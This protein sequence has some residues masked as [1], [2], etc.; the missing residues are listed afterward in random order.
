M[1]MKLIMMAA[2]VAVSGCVH[3][4]DPVGRGELPPGQPTVEDILTGLSENE[5]ALL[6]FRA[7]GT[8][9][10]KIP[11][12][13]ATQV[14]RESTLLFLSP[15]RLNVVGRR[16]GTRGIELTYVDDAFLIEFPTRREYCFKD[17]EESFETLSSAD[18]VR[19]MFTPE[20]WRDLSPR[21]VRITEYD[22]ES[23]TAELE[24]WTSERPYWPR[25][26]IRVQGAPWVL[27]ENVM[28]N[29]QGDVIARTV[30]SAYHEQAGIR[31]PTEIE[32]VFPGED[33]WM[34]FI[35][36][37]VDINLALDET[38]FNLSNRLTRLQS[39]GF[40]RVDIFAGEG[41]SIEDLLKQQQ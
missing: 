11:E 28:L 29:R 32:S 31:Y 21:D 22:E 13:D 10:V 36:R 38:V 7:S 9:M 30:K 15:N 26:I 20:A 41:P 35:M 12:I 25:R 39:S 17:M 19:E 6:S 40:K 14:S 5:A 24:I 33:A 8:I 34:R 3:L 16:Y 37:R 18:I 4:G 23:Q 2:L 27:L 1:N